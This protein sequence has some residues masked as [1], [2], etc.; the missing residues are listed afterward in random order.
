MVGSLGTAATAAVGSTVTVNWLIG[1]T[2]SAFGVGFLSYISQAIGAGEPE[3]ARRAAAQSVLMVLAAG[4]LFTGLTLGLSG[5]VPVWMQVAPSLRAVASRYFFILYL[6][7]LPRAA[8]IIFGTVLRAAGDTKT[9]MRVGIRVNLIN[10]TLNFL[11]IYPTR[12]ITLLGRNLTIWG[13]G[14]GVVGAA[15]ASAVAFLY[16]GLAI[17]R[18]L[19]HHPRISP[20]GLSLR[21]D[22]AILAPCLRVAFPNMLQRFG[23]SLGYVAFAAMI[24]A[25]GETATAAHTIAN[26]VES[27][28]YIPG[29]GMQTAAATLT[30]NAVGAG[31][32][33]RARDLARLIFLCEVSLML[34]SGGLLF[35]FA[36]AMVGLFSRDAAVILLGSTV[37]RMVA[38]SEPFYG[39]SIVIEGMLQGVGKT[40]V[41]FVFNVIGMWGVR[42]VGTFLCTRLLG[43]GLVSAWGCMIGHNMLL[44]V[45]FVW[46]FRRG[47]WNPLEKE[48]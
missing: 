15:A 27:A 20:R 30:G 36:P 34:M 38:C 12:S 6:P 3:R 26:T 9:P 5:R 2:V 11:M 42:I 10:V 33:Q 14:W 21:P 43:L 18:A 23:T 39:V 16:G 8:S 17:T 32:R 19:F 48:R 1:S 22:G 47:R 37:L 35:A 45:L 44:F 24:N 40:A 4:L 13:A 7:M 28:F 31:D 46:Y 41:P 25:L 29:Y